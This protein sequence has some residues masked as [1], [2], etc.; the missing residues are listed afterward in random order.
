[1]F[2]LFVNPHPLSLGVI[3]FNAK[4]AERQFCVCALLL[5]LCD[6]QAICMTNIITVTC[7]YFIVYY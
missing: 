6:N 2:V 3:C 5:L 1:M 7:D 4:I